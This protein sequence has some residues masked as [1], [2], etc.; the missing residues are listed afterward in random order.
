MAAAAP[1]HRATSDV[2]ML[3]SSS[4]S[5]SHMSGSMLQVRALRLRAPPPTPRPRPPRRRS[6]A[7][8]YEAA[9][10][11]AHAACYPAL[12]LSSATCLELLAP[13]GWRL[14]HEIVV[15]RGHRLD[16]LRQLH[17]HLGRRLRR[18][19]SR[20]ALL[21]RDELDPLGVRGVARRAREAVLG[22]LLGQRQLEERRVLRG[23]ARGA[24][25]LRRRLLGV[26][27]VVV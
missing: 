7:A 18:G 22:K 11:D 10:A 9:H 8:T 2:S 25:E 19:R 23:E 24:R 17:L 12:A 4:P 3:Q 27:R 20:I 16:R 26:R 15:P 5:S 1:M 13:L 21:L 6:P 14:L